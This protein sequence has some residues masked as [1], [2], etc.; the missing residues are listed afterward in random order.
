MANPGGIY[1]LD[2]AAR[3]LCTVGLSVSSS[4]PG[5]RARRELTLGERVCFGTLLGGGVE[6]GTLDPKFSQD[7]LDLRMDLSITNARPR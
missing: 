4:H 1:V 6:V 2:S 5:A 3:F 7:F